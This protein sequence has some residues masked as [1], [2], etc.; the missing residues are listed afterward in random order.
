MDID[1]AISEA[2]LQ[3]CDC[4]YSKYFITN[5]QLL[6]GSSDKEIIYQALLLTTDGKPAEEIRTLLQRWVL[7]K[8]FI[9]VN[10]NHHQLDPYCSVMIHEIGIV[11]CDPI[12]PTLQPSASGMG[13][14]VGAAALVTLLLSLIIATVG[15]VFSCYAL[16]R[17]RLKKAKERIR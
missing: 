6:C 11:S 16:K 7:T 14:R 1:V 13:P 9:T 2:I 8:P 15:T 5:G 3:T 4:E 17:Y 12:L 10:E